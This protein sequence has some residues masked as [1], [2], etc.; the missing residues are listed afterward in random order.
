MTFKYCQSAVDMFLGLPL[1]A[2]FSSVFLRTVHTMK[3]YAKYLANRFWGIT[4]L[5]H[6]YHFMSIQL[7]YLCKLYLFCCGIN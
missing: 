5:I 2:L 4:L 7:M 1:L 3:R 6:K